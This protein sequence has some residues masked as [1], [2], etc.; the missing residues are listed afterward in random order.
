[1]NIVGFLQAEYGI[2]PIHTGNGIIAMPRPE[3]ARSAF[4]VTIN[5]PLNGEQIDEIVRFG[6]KS[7][8]TLI[9]ELYGCCNG[10]N[11][12][13]TKFFIYGMRIEPTGSH[14]YANR[15]IP[16][17]LNTPNLW[18][19]MIELEDTS[20]IIAKSTQYEGESHTTFVH[21]IDANDKISTRQIDDIAK[22]ITSYDSLEVWLKKELHAAMSQKDEW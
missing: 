16:F 4:E 2:D 15:N 5:A 20:L 10:L 7:S 9:R 22:I 13:A 18:E 8:E 17:D 12:G 21:T 6:Q 14:P 1:M 11:I 3:V 19:R